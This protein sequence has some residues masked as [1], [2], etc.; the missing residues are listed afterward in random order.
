MTTRVYLAALLNPTAVKTG[1]YTALVNDRVLVDTSSA[2]V[3][4]TLPSA[5]ADK[6]RIDVQLVA[7][8][9]TNLC[10]IA[11]QGTDV[12]DK[13]GGATSLTLK[14]FGQMVALQYEASAGVW[15]V[16]YTGQQTLAAKRTKY[17]GS[18]TTQSQSG[19]AS[20][21]AV[22]LAAVTFNYGLDT[23]TNADAI[24][25]PAGLG[26]LY[27][28]RG[29]LWWDVAGSG[30]RSVQLWVNGSAVAE[31]ALTA[32]GGKFNV[33]TV[34]ALAA[35]DIVKLAAY[36]DNTANIRADGVNDITLSV[37]KVG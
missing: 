6:S 20:A 10:T 37:V 35:G 25:I 9:G 28:L 22:T 33:F 21:A 23:T 26:G 5:P 30:N 13:A 3:T 1:A 17:N 34:R 2:A 7:A 19:F 31:V 14:S 27:D 16:A 15:H 36:T 8:N 29:T 4:I 32:T 18:A 11:R 12:F 24:T